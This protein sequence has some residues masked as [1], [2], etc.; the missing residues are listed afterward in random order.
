MAAVDGR[1]AAVVGRIQ[2]LGRLRHGDGS[3]RRRATRV[4][5]NAKRAMSAHRSFHPPGTPFLLST[6]FCL[7]FVSS[8]HPSQINRNVDDFPREIS[9]H[10]SSSSAATSAL[11]FNEASRLVLPFLTPLSPSL[12]SSLSPRPLL[13]LFLCPTLSSKD[14]SEA[15]K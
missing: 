13:F 7:F 15:E 11:L 4:Q 9:I 6:P 14:E 10:N 3:A 1:R 8:F 5:R 12:L 2:Q